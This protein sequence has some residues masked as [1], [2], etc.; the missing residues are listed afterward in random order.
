MRRGFAVGNAAAKCGSLAGW[1]CNGS[2]AVSGGAAPA[3]MKSAAS[4]SATATGL[5]FATVQDD[6]ASFVADGALESGMTYRVMAEKA[7][8]VTLAAIGDSLSLDTSLVAYAGEVATTVAES[9]IEKTADGSVTTYT[10]VAKFGVDWGTDG[11]QSVWGDEPPTEEELAEIKS[12]AKANGLDAVAVNSEAGAAAYL[13]GLAFVPSSV[14]TLEIVSIDFAADGWKVEVKVAADGAP[15]AFGS[16]MN[17]SLTVLTAETL[18]GEWTKQA[19][20]AANVTFAED[21]SRAT[22]AVTSAEARF[23]K[24][25]VTK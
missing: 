6:V 9:E 20:N 11:M 17:G 13:L 14:P 22:V 7:P 8:D 19:Y 21:R 24:V 10:V 4:V 16:A 5:F 1:V 3:A 2:L 25:A 18:D 12:W 15:L 23:I